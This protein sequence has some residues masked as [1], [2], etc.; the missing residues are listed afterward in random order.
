VEL[1]R[2]RELTLRN[3]QLLPNY[4]L[5]ELVEVVLYERVSDRHRNKVRVVDFLAS[6][7]LLLIILVA[8]T[9][10]SFLISGRALVIYHNLSD[11][12]GVQDGHAVGRPVDVQGLK[13][14]ITEAVFA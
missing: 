11:V 8:T 7:A 5:L 4:G 10:R 3:A 14:E 9:V 13:R 2:G 6:F 12:G 1:G